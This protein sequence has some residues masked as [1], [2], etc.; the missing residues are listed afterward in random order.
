MQDSNTVDT[1]LKFNEDMFLKEDLN[2]LKNRFI[3]CSDSQWNTIR[4]LNLKNPNTLILISVFAGIWGVDRFMINKKSSGTLKL[5]VCQLSII[6]G[7]A[8]IFLLLSEDYVGWGIFCLL[9]FIT[10]ELW[11][12]ID[13]CLIRK[14][15]KEYNYNFISRILNF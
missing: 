15:T 13:I 12:L 1:Y 7:I 9:L 14:L 5:V 10:G 8:C 2:D 3:N 4:F 6:A 11:W